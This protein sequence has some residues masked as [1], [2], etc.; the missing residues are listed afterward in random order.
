M[1]EWHTDETVKNLLQAV[2]SDI[3]CYLLNPSAYQPEYFED[4]HEALVVAMHKLGYQTIDEEGVNE[5]GES[6]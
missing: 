3:A 4:I 1:S 5:E 6:K 2:E